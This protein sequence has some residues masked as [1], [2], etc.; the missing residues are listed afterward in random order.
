MNPDIPTTLF[1]RCLQALC[2]A[3]TLHK[4]SKYCSAS[5]L[6]RISSRLLADQNSDNMAK[7]CKNGDWEAIKEMIQNGVSCDVDIR[8]PQ[9]PYIPYHPIDL[10]IH[11]GQ[12]AAAYVLLRAG[13]STVGI[14][15]AGLQEEVGP[16]Q[17]NSPLLFKLILEGGEIQENFRI[18][19]NYAEPYLTQMACEL[20]DFDDPDFVQDSTGILRD[21]RGNY[22]EAFTVSIVRNFVTILTC[23]RAFEKVYE[24]CQGESDLANV[25][26]NLVPEIFASGG[27]HTKFIELLFTRLVQD[28]NVKVLAGLCLCPALSDEQKRLAKKIDDVGVFRSLLYSRHLTL[29]DVGCLIA[30]LELPGKEEK[31]LYRLAKM[32]LT[33]YPMG[34]LNTIKRKIRVSRALTEF[35]LMLE[36]KDLLMI[37]GHGAPILCNI[38]G[39]MQVEEDQMTDE[40]NR[41]RQYFPYLGKR[42]VLCVQNLL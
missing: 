8:R 15:T 21:P 14:K 18:L 6:P 23:Q 34:P 24:A 31:L 22:L 10:A 11:N 9:H 26:H 35:L 39:A 32:G 20:T 38:A 7:A 12:I 1:V 29:P 25:C 28:G 3:Y 41:Y 17:L 13:C 4:I 37:F 2:L 42:S 33:D 30:K 19:L 27:D 5:P 40:Q 36:L 16:F